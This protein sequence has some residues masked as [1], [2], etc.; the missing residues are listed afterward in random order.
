MGHSKNMWHIKGGGGCDSV[1]VI[2]WQAGYGDNQSVT[3]LDNDFPFWSVYSLGMLVFW[4]MKVL[5]ND[6]LKRGSKIGKKVSRI[7]WMAP[8]HSC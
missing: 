7:I 4:K 8:N 3:F 2:K 6:T 5:P 1:R